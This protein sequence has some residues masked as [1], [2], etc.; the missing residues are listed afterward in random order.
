MG[1]SVMKT[2]LGKSVANRLIGKV[3]WSLHVP[4]DVLLKKSADLFVIQQ[5]KDLFNSSIW[6]NLREITLPMKTLS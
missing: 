5:K 2:K 4:T 3:N 1:D 6:E